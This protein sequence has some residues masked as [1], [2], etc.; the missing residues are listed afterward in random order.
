MID[1]LKAALKVLVSKRQTIN[2]VCKG[3]DPINEDELRRII[4][5]K[6]ESYDLIG[7]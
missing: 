5:A 3:N 1:K 4:S 7:K 6:R 2:I